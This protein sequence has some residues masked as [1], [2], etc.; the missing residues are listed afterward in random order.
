VRILHV[1][2]TYFPDSQGGLEE[3]IRQI[4]LNT[5]PLGADSRVM[6]LSSNPSRSILRREE[7]RVY[8]PKMNFEVASCGISLSAFAYFKRLVSWADVVHYHYPWPFADLLHFGARVRKPTVLTYHSDIVR[9]KFLGKLYAPLRKRFLSSVDQIICT[10]P[11]YFAT[12]DVLT[13]YEDKVSVVPIGLNESS[14][15]AADD[16]L[17]SSMRKQY[18]DNF[19]LFVGV[20]RYYKG[21]HIL[22][23]AIKDA[24]FKVVIV[25]SGPTEAELKRQALDL[26]LTNVVFAGQL[27]DPEKVALFKLSRAV[28]FPSYL[29]AEAFGVT[30]LE[31]AMY[32]KPLISTEVGS[33]T[34]HVNID[35]ETGLVV[36]PGSAKALREAM[37]QLHSQPEM[38]EQMGN[39]ARAR[40]ERLFT[41]SLM[42][43]RYFELYES[44]TGTAA[45]DANVLA[46]ADGR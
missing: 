32:N 29:R 38:A 1:Y 7:G 18:G 41:G 35:G 46:V 9:Q 23:D 44:V 14:Y 5:K 13:R 34:S 42:G 15:P 3:V 45:E 26:K 19:F 31:G 10:S 6:S 36:P 4:C 25:G 33:G 11:N 21:L 12:S 37:E 17:L 27:E 22:L 28:V 24:P 43:R 20:L 30:L 16:G 40:Y 2:R 8:R 39:R